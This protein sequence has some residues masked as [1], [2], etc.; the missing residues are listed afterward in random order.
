MTHLSNVSF[1]V[2]LLCG[3]VLLAGCNQPS[4]LIVKIPAEKTPASVVSHPD[5]TDITPGTTASPND[6]IHR[7]PEIQGPIEDADYSP[8]HDQ[9]VLA[10]D[11]AW[12]LS[13]AM[14]L[15]AVETPGKPCSVSIHEDRAAI[16]Y[17][18]GVAL[19]SLRSGNVET[20]IAVQSEGRGSRSGCPSVA[21]GNAD[22]FVRFKL[23]SGAEL[24]RLDL[25]GSEVSRDTI[26]VGL[27]DMAIRPGSW[28]SDLYA[29]TGSSTAN[30]VHYFQNYDGEFKSIQVHSDQKL[31]P[32][33]RF[34]FSAD[35][36]HLFTQN[37]HVFHA[38]D[39][40]PE[41]KPILFQ[42]DLEPGVDLSYTFSS[43]PGEGVAS[44]CQAGDVVASIPM[45]RGGMATSQEARDS[46]WN[47]VEFFRYPYLEEM[48]EAPF[49]IF[50][51]DDEIPVL[52]KGRF[53]FC[54]GDG[55]TAYVLM[56]NGHREPEHL[57]WGAMA[58][59]VPK[60]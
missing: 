12:I 33:R 16:G 48:G 8:V 11:D 46:H 55:K 60:S 5:S 42:R 24:V 14:R 20:T 1:R 37:G 54:K 23:Y 29:L 50:A 49:P 56:D 27:A 21:L 3:L 38:N 57:A 22:L 7:L 2:L 25:G 59:N 17:D 19:L 4:E 15:K 32:G 52:S 44:V 39:Q 45:P 18:G 28:N 51:I 43:I 6:A 35:G 31:R 53:V 41:E 30:L 13:G 47:R 26:A 9:M 34:W 40:P 10:A 58:L 36:Q